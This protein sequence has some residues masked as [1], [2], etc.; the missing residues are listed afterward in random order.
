MKPSVDAPAALPLSRE[1][2]DSQMKSATHVALNV[3]GTIFYTDRSTLRCGSDVLRG[4]VDRSFAG[5]PK[6]DEGRPFLD[7]SP[8]IFQ[9]LLNF[10]RGY[11][12]PFTPEQAVA[13]MEDAKY[14]ECR[15]LISLL[16]D[17]DTALPLFLPG[18]GVSGDRRTF[19]SKEV[20]AYCS[21]DFLSKG[22]HVLTIRAEKC[23]L[24]C[25]GAVAPGS[26]L[27]HDRLMHSHD[28]SICYMSAGH[29]HQR[30]SERHH[31]FT[32]APRYREGDHVTIGLEYF[33]EEDAAEIWLAKGDRVV[34]RTVFEHCPPL[35]IGVSL[36]GASIAVITSSCREDSARARP[37]STAAGDVTSEAL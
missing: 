11:R 32:E 17:E 22:R 25:I 33:S 1:G 37:D 8:T 9:L 12:A 10:L 31:T 6:D 21:P 28:R 29:V 24:V 36:E 18:P 3:G 26:D 30:I 34:Y 35:K 20:T 5:F 7:R 14:F 23:D 19:S 2:K 13:L 27:G 16:G 4:L 15:D